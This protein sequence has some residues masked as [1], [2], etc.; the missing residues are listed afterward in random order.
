MA[1]APGSNTGGG[2]GGGVERNAQ[3][4]SF[5]RDFLAFELPGG[6]YLSRLE[7]ILAEGKTRLVSSAEGRC[8]FLSFFS[9]FFSRL[10]LKGGIQIVNA[11]DLRAF[12]GA[13]TRL[14]IADPFEMLPHWWEFFFLLFVALFFHGF[15]AKRER[16]L[17]DV[18]EEKF[19]GKE[20]FLFGWMDSPIFF[21]L[22]DNF[23][24]GQTANWD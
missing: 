24:K 22:P 12:D 11:D 18:V 1:L 23:F 4:E 20:V 8:L 13:L 6:T 5:F 19:P 17:A 7:S 10:F 21:F 2:G 16:C 3:A 15:P 9:L 14:F